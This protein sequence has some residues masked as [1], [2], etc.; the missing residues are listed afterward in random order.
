MWIERTKDGWMDKGR[1]ACLRCWMKNRRSGAGIEDDYIPFFHP[2]SKAWEFSSQHKLVCRTVLGRGQGRACVWD[3]I[4]RTGAYGSIS[5]KDRLLPRSKCREKW[6]EDSPS[7]YCGR[8]KGGGWSGDLLESNRSTQFWGSEVP[9]PK[10]WSNRA[11]LDLSF[12]CTSE[13]HPY[14]N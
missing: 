2:R 10:S 1:I 3:L 5:G 6:S 4:P 8:Q 11:W 13:I 14:I 7:L 12:L 9:Y